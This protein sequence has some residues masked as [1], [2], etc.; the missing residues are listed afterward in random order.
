M[1][2]SLMLT[3]A[4]AALGLTACNAQESSERAVEEAGGSVP[5]MQRTPSDA[6]DRPSPAATTGAAG[7]TTSAADPNPTGAGAT[8]GARPGDPS[9]A[10]ASTPT[11]LPQPQTSNTPTPPK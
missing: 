5:T 1:R 7:A 6:E 8:A 11:T 10:M 9:G 2:L 4:A 3:A